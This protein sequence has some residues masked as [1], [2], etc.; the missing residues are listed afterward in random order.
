MRVG[1]MG[2]REMRRDMGTPGDQ[3]WVLGGTKR[4]MGAWGSDSEHGPKGV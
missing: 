1:S 4:I 2:V 3:G